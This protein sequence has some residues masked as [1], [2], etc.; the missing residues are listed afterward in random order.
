[1]TTLKEKIADIILRDTHT[2]HRDDAE[3]AVDAILAAVI[4]HATSN[5]ARDRARSAYATN[6]TM[7]VMFGETVKLDDDEAWL[8]AIR[9]AIEGE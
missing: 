6:I 2:Y 8:T 9:A 1:M 3:T 5:E 7:K 4:E